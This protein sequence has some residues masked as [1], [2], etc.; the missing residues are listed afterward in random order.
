MADVKKVKMTIDEE[1]KNLVDCVTT[2]EDYKELFSIIIEKCSSKYTM[3][4]IYTGIF[5]FTQRTIHHLFCI[6]KE[7]LI[8]QCIE[9]LGLFYKDKIFLMHSQYHNYKQ[10]KKRYLICV[11]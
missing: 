10:D 3:K 2:L 6:N 7:Y 1:Y 9:H 8:K 4:E 11:F 5:D